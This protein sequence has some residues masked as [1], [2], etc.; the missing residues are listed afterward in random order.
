MP[1][2]L[3]PCES[4]QVIQE[5]FVN[6]ITYTQKMENIRQR[7]YVS[8]KHW[9]RIFDACN[10]MKNVRRVSRTVKVTEGELFLSRLARGHYNPKV[11]E[12]DTL[13]E[14]ADGTWY[15]EKG[16]MQ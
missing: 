13:V 7:I 8:G 3:P 10:A 12:G 9:G 1:H 4:R 5:T 14:L 11:A 16:D 15:V 6:K 2:P